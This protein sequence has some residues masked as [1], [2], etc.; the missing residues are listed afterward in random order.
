MK[1]MI[2]SCWWRELNQVALKKNNKKSHPKKMWPAM[3]SGMR[4]SSMHLESIC[5]GCVSSTRSFSDQ[6]PIEGHC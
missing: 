5:L 2:Q 4:E 1:I 3:A 6:Q